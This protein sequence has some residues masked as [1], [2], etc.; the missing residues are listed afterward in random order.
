MGFRTNRS[1]IDNIFIVRQ[2]FEKCHEYNIELNNIFI[3]YTH[4]FDL[5]H[6]KKILECLKQYE[7]PSKL[8]KLIAL[9]LENTKAKVKVNNDLSGEIKIETGVKQG[10]PLSATVFSIII[11]SIMN[12]LDVRGNISIRLKQSIAYADNILI[13][14]RTTQAAIDTF[15]KLKEQSYKY[16]LVINTQKTKYLKCAKEHIK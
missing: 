5:V 2:I 8:I 15:Q 10:D 7:V 16:G 9:M 4:A 11:D 6:P 13:T 3:D 12:Q 1:T 14:A